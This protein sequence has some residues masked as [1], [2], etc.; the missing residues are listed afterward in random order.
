M[1]AKN[2]I[3]LLTGAVVSVVFR[4]DHIRSIKCGS[5]YIGLREGNVRDLRESGST[6]VDNFTVKRENSDL[7]F[8]DKESKKNILSLDYQAFLQYVI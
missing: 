4:D 5:I 8:V 2:F 7:L 3:D 1:K 6:L